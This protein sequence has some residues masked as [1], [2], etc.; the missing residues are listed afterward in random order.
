MDKQTRKI[1]VLSDSSVKMKITNLKHIKRLARTKDSISKYMCTNKYFQI[2]SSTEYI[3]Y[4]CYS[5]NQQD[6]HSSLHPLLASRQAQPVH[7][8][9][10]LKQNLSTGGLFLHIVKEDL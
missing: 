4:F 9:S 10:Q 1:L 7:N 8:K 6:F 2:A 3:K 5:T